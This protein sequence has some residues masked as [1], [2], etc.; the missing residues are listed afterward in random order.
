VQVLEIQLL[1][2]SSDMN[3][4]F[5]WLRLH[6]SAI[7]ATTLAV[8]KA[9]ALSSGASAILTAIAVAFGASA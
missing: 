3:Q 4:V 6:S 5:Q 8:A 9:G 1:L 7:L 2:E